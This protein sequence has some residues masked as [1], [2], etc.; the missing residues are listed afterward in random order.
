MKRN[1]DLV[2][3]ILIVIEGIHLPTIREIVKGVISCT[4]YDKEDIEGHCNLLRR[5]KLIEEW[6]PSGMSMTWAGYD[7][8]D[9]LRN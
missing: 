8:L 2:R 6:T 1:M 3:G 5:S 9:R 7:L 4:K